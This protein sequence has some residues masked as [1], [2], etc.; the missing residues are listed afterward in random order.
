MLGLSFLSP[1]EKWQLGPFEI[2]YYTPKELLGTLWSEDSTADNAIAVPENSVLDALIEE[3]DTVTAP[4]LSEETEMLPV[5]EPVVLDTAIQS[6]D[7]KLFAPFFD[8][9]HR[10]SA[11]PNSRVRVLHFG[12]S[13][14]EGDRITMQ[15]RDAYQRNYGGTGFGYVALQPLVAPSSLAFENEEG[16]VRKTVFGRRDS[17]FSDRKYGLLGSFS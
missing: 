11:D 3:T 10:L 14:L 16:L 15:L 13:Q 5:A 1:K 9:L 12:D 8:A 2:G 17:A 7:V 4:L 6:V